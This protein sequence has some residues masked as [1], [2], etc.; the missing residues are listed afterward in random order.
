MYTKIRYSAKDLA[1]WTRLEIFFFTFYALIVSGSYFYFDIHDV[2]VPWTPIALI[3]TAV[4]FVVGFQNNSAYGRIWEARKIWGGVVNESRTF[5]M[6]AKDFISNHHA[7]DKWP[8]DKLNENRKM[9]VL[10]HVAW[11]TSLRHAMRQTKS[12]EEFENYKTNR[13]W[14]QKAFI[15]E[16][17]TKLED[18][19]SMYLSD[20]ELDY[21]LSKGN[22][23]SAVLFLQSKHL[24]SLMESGH[25]WEF[26]FLELEKVIQQL[27]ALQ[28][29]SERIKNFPYPRQY[30]S[31]NFYFVK[32]LLIVLPWGLI[33]EFYTVSQIISD[34]HMSNF[35]FFLSVPFYILISWLFNTMERIG[36]VGENPFEGSAND[37]PISTI[38]RSIEIDIRQ[39]LGCP[40]DDIP[41]QFPERYG[42]QM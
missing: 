19:L 27:F 37:V 26:S 29:K 31:L 8:E 9:L 41:N 17:V 1:L 6:M 34:P 28:G 42:V 21:V 11:L 24:K 15:P 38:A 16:R 4:A 18:E 13:E 22:K 36:R 5:A 20:E 35:V 40:L 30:A 39:Q 12:W 10:R 32:I 14:S 33:P 3:G 2:R 23:A 7:K 25:I